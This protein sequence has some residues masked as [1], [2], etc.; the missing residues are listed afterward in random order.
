MAT[1]TYDSIGVSGVR[2]KKILSLSIRHN[3]NEHGIATIRGEVDS[4]TG[5]ED[6]ARLTD[7][8]LIQITTTAENQPP[9]LFSGVVLSTKLSCENDYM[10]LEVVIASTSYLLDIKKNNRSFQNTAITYQ[11]LFTQTLNGNGTVEMNVTDK[12]TGTIVM[13]Y[14]ETDWE[15]ILRLASR[16]HTSV[17]VDVTSSTPKIIIGMPSSVKTISK[18]FLLGCATQNNTS[19]TISDIQTSVSEG[20]SFEYGFVGDKFA[21]CGMIVK[22]YAELEN[23]ILKCTYG[24]GTVSLF[25]VP[26]EKKNTQVAGRMFIGKVEEV[27]A[28]K[29][30]VHLTDIDA[31]YDTGG[32]Y[33]FPYSTAY[34]SGD[35]SG[36]YCMP[37]VDDQ[38]RVFFPTENESD[39]FAASSV[40]V[41]PPENPLH[42]IWKNSYG[43]EILMTPE[44]VKITCQGTSI[45]I[46]L[47]DA[48][49]ITIHSDKQVKVTSKEK[50]K[51][52]SDNLVE[53]EGK[54]EVFL[55][56]GESF[57]DILPE[58]ITFSGKEMLIN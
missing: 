13:Q 50:V 19:G 21:D 15:F 58:G 31:E 38:V 14:N 27:S 20:V 1:I 29:V 28:D 34:S 9:C 11:E 54:K 46:E 52:E 47:S 8:S 3:I 40:N 37:A 18:S 26:T 55:H 16:F 45:Y 42:K 30:K 22:V 57:I 17:I 24:Y 49:G 6:A 25:R 5:Q 56:A 41:A 44:G 7:T 53:I 43:K 32:S 10:I 51:I 2:F 4:V 36:F 12:V 23:G 48:E 39:A 33:W 35:G